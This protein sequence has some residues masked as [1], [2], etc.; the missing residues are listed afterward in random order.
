[1]KRHLTQLVTD[2]LHLG[3]GQRISPRQSGGAY[4]GKPVA[5]TGTVWRLEGGSMALGGGSMALTEGSMA[6]IK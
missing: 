2:D 3:P 5:P 4:G 6:S 1:M